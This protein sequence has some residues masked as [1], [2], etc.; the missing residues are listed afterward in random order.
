MRRA[1]GRR[2]D[3]ADGVLAARPRLAPWPSWTRSSACCA[4]GSRGRPSSCTTRPRP[5]SLTCT[6]LPREPPPQAELTNPQERLNKEIKRRTRVVGIFPT[7]ASLMRL[8][9]A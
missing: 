7:R 8:V 9:W 5:T 3:R 1:G 2:G 6:S 4:L